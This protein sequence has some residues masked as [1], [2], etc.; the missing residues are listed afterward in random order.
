[1]FNSALPLIFAFPVPLC[2]AAQDAVL[3]PAKVA[4]LKTVTS[5]AISADGAHL[6]YT[7]SVP[8]EPMVDDDGVPWTELHVIDNATNQDRTYVG[9]K[10]GV[11]QVKF[12]PD[13]STLYFLDKRGDDKVTALYGI[14]LDGGEARLALRMD[15]AVSAYS[16]SHDGKHAAVIATEAEPAAKKKAGDKGFKQEV[17]EE[18][19]Y[20]PRVFVIEL[21]GENKDPKALELPGSANQ[22]VWSPVDGRLALALSPTPLVDDEML[23]SRVHVADSASGKIL[24]RFENPG[25]LGQIAWSP[26]GQWIACVSAED[27]NDT[28]AG[29]IFCAPSAGGPITD[30]RPKYLGHVERLAWLDAKR[31][32]YVAAEGVWSY[33]GTVGAP[34]SGLEPAQ[35][36]GPGGAVMTDLV[37][38]GDGRQLALLGSTPSQPANA[39]SLSVG[40]AS[41]QLRTRANPGL[42]AVRMALQEVV[43]FKARDG[44]ELEGI[45]IR[46]LDEK[47]GIRYPLILN[48]HGG[49]EA[50]QSNGWLTGYSGPGQMAA[51]RGMAVFHIN[52][53]GSTGRGVEFAKLSQGD[54]A[55][56][57][58]NDL[59]D[60]VD[61]LV[62]TGLVDS[63]RVGVT[64]GSYG[65]YATG[66]LCTAHSERFAAGVMFVGISDKV[67]KVGTTDI[68]NEEFMVHSRK[69]PWDD[70]A[71]L[72]ERS[73]I[74]HA[75]KCKTPLLIMHGKD[76]P[77]V[78]VGQSRELFRHLKLRSQAPV[79]L[80]LYPGEGHGN[81]KAASRYDYNL[82]LLQWLEHYL[83]GP[84]GEMPP[85]EIDYSTSLTDQ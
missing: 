11:S 36:L 8:R 21:F 40:D 41:P 38:S 1:M 14:A 73:P 24:A 22:V 66:W 16:L 3:T 47:Q 70:W 48:V 27:P 79:R 37:A 60:G 63:A 85:Y 5:V 56:A 72:L 46:P 45:L 69:R 15:T 58:F 6:A 78:N 74:T 61:Y 25:K 18:D 68:A 10:S 30:L 26:D 57:E 76:D 9:G 2:A 12:S 59:I 71:M 62:G 39:F 29:R 64:G 50:C 4:R 7:L 23:N 44:Q 83:V 81:R 54:P 67:S 49:P 28:A 31:L 43:R 84:G 42:D 75:G 17:Y 55:G 32:A 20:V 77:R 51:A 82:R 19:F 53:R 52:Y 34:K 35:L 33:V 65:G 80:V 13:G